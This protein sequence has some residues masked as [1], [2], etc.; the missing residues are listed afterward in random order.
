MMKNLL[1][2]NTPDF[3]IIDVIESQSPT[4]GRF[5]GFGDFLALIVNIFF[6]IGAGMSVIGLLL[7]G[8]RY[9]MAKSDIKAKQQA[10]QALT[11]SI[12]AFILVFGAYTIYRIIITTLGS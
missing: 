1:A 5:T 11:Y 2:G 6:G 3:G 8:I 10:Q 9:T 4:A 12:V 7:A